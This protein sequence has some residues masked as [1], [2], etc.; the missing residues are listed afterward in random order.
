MH[1]G[2]RGQHPHLDRGHG[3]I[4]QHGVQLRGH[5]LG[6][7]RV[8]RGYPQAVLDREGRD[9][10]EAI[11][12]H[13]GSHLQILLQARPGARVGAGNNQHGFHG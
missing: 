6:G 11:G 7:H 12:P 9:H 3:E 4:A 1:Q 10:R 8:D 13:Q 2:R 5:H